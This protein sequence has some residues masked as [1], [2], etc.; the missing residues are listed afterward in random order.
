MN[1][2]K[3]KRNKEPKKENSRFSGLKTES[4][5]FKSQNRSNSRN[6]S[7]SNSDGSYV[8]PSK[9][10]NKQVDESDQNRFA[11]GIY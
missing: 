8:P 6:R 4:N 7:N 1:F 3:N 9:R 10:N 5:P 2:N 11:A